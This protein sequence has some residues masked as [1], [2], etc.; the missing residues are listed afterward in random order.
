MGTS[1]ITV[2]I[3]RYIY[4]H[5][6]TTSLNELMEMTWNEWKDTG[7]SLYMLD[8]IRA[9]ILATYIICCAVNHVAPVSGYCQRMEGEPC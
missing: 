1:D 8:G 5:F 4:D 6:R 3:N 2:K 9:E 7:T